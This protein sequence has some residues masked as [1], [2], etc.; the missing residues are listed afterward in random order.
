M[1][2]SLLIISFLFL[3]GCEE[4][5]IFGLERGWL[6]TDKNSDENEGGD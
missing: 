5:P 3:F 2:K 4:D 1:P 6:R